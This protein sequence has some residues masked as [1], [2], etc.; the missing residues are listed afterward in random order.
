M[1]K[2]EPDFT[3]DTFAQ[4][5]AVSYAAETRVEKGLESFWMFLWAIHR[6][7][8]AFHVAADAHETALYGVKQAR[9]LAMAS[10]QLFA[11]HDRQVSR[12]VL[13]DQRAKRRVLRIVREN[14][15]LDFVTSN[16]SPP[17]GS[18]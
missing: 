9:V 5:C 2:P 10:K 7:G 3:T 14:A 4:A 8:S 17:K 11:L 12:R 18:R 1:N 6:K 15:V 13:Q 16:P